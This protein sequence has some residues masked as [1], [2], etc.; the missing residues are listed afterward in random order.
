[1][2]S[3]KLSYLKYFHKTLFVGLLESAS[4]RVEMSVEVRLSTIGSPQTP[5]KRDLH[6][7]LLLL[8]L[9][10]IITTFIPVGFSKSIPIPIPIVYFG[11][12]GFYSGM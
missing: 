11:Y 3:Q 12:Y 9:C 2:F 7:E 10:I 4:L 1:M 6:W 8:L 5:R